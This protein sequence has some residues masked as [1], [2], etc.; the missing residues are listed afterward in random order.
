MS[1][2]ALASAGDAYWQWVLRTEPTWATYLSDPRYNDQLPR[3][4]P[5]D[6]DRQ[7][8]ELRAQKAQAAAIDPAGLDDADQVTRS[9]LGHL[10]GSQI[11][12]RELKFHQWNI[13]Q[14]MGPQVWLLELINYHPFR[15]EKD[16]LD[17]IS[18][19]QAFPRYVD[20]HLANLREGLEQGRVAPKVAVTR[21][22]GQ[23]EALLAT[24]PEKSPLALALVKRPPTASSLDDRIQAAIR[25]AVYPAYAKYLA[26]LKSD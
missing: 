15:I 23:L 8:A 11:E 12:E 16:V 2:S 18:R 6:V 22:V 4:G 7:L 19:F 20:E 9:I 3:I 13:D 26:F 14:M 10:I 21:V 5:A 17:L 24:P 25:D 1:S